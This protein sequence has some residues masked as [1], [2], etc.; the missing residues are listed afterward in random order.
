MEISHIVKKQRQYFDSGATRD[1]EFR[2]A[3]LKKLRQAIR[4]REGQLCDAMRADLGKSA[5]EAYMC[6]VGLTLSE[7]SYQIR[8][9]RKWARPKR[10]GTDLTNFHG[11]SFSVREPYGCVL[12]MSPWNYPFLLCVEPMIGAIAAGN[13][14]VLKP[15]AYSPATSAAIRELMQ[16]VF[17]QEYVAVVEGGRAENSALLEERFDYIFF[18]GGVTVGKLV[19]EK[20]AAHLTPVTLELGG[21][22]PC[23]VDQTADLKLVAARIAF[24]K[25]LNCGQTCVAPDYLLI[26][27]SVKEAFLEQFRAAVEGMYGEKPLENPDYGKIINRKHFDR[28]MGLM[29]PGSVVRDGDAKPERVARDGEIEPGKHAGNREVD[30]GRLVWGGETDPETLR[31]APAVM[32]FVSPEDAV[33]QEEIFGPIL[34][35]LTFEDIDQAFAFVRKREKPLAAYLFTRDKSTE[36][37]FLE[38]V[39]FGGGCINDTIMHLA[40]SRMGFGG[41]GNSGMGSYHGIK[42]FETFSHEKNVLKKYGWIDLPLRYQPYNGKK[43]RLVRMFLK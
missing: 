42:S 10:R 36:K 27:S 32:D 16:E 25:Y 14:C 2:I 31:I 28:L 13:C 20:A 19:M 38:T 33:M 6:E 41:V 26:H 29:V 35:V 12:I 40:T 23:I 1:V 39:S 21:K 30:P 17:P 7:L 18:T 43:D 8:H 11:R 5:S 22:S 15:S 9:L 24:G 3:A 34:P 37:Q 4:A